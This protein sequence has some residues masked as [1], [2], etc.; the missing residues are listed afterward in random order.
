[1]SFSTRHF[2]RA[3]AALLIVPMLVSCGGGGTV[4]PSSVSSLRLLDADLPTRKAVNYSP[5]RTSTSEAGLNSEVIPPEN[6]LQDLRLMQAAGFRLIRVFDSSD[7]IA[8]QTIQAIAANGLDFKVQ[9]G[10][11]ISGSDTAFNQAEIARA[12]ALANAY[13]T[14]VR[15]VSVGNEKMASFSPD[16]VAP[17][18]LAGYITQVRN[19]ITQ[20][21]T[22]D[23]NYAVWANISTA[24]SGAV[25]YASVHV[26]PLLDTYYD[27]NLW[28]WRQASVPANQRG[29]A[30]MAAAVTEARRQVSTA[31]AALDRKGLAS[32]PIVIG[33]TGW[34]AVDTTG[35]PNLSNRAGVPNQKL[36]FQGLQTWQAEG[37][38]GSGPKAIF[39]FEAFDEQ[40]KQGDDG[41][42][43]FN[44]NR[45]AR[46]VVQSQGTCNVTWTCE[47]GTYTDA[48][49]V[50][51]IPPTETTP[52][53]TDRY[54][55]YSDVIASS[56]TYESA[57][58]WDAFG[59]NTAVGFFDNST[60]ATGD[61]PFSFRITP[62]PANYGWGMLRQSSASTVNLSQFAS[63]SLHVS[64]RTTYP[65]KIELGLG[66]DTFDRSGAEAYI[67]L[68]PGSGGYANDDAWH[69]LV[70][71]I[72]AF[73]AVNPN[74][75][76][77]Y[78][79]LRFIIAN[80]YSATGN[81]TSSTAPIYID[82]V[83][84]TK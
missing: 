84:W 71:P 34:T 19:A 38:S 39:Y 59:G 58:T 45:E 10:L 54:R 55:I 40:W 3:V 25:D 64:I 43:L 62:A 47:A 37:V 67:Q 42:G 15:A 21:V 72:S 32:M 66:T 46:Y 26:Y 24:I 7:K 12:I 41:W 83:Y 5:F 49:A 51:F 74:I 29:A 77:R 35:G 36:Y 82:G 1:M 30:M 60:S 76:L 20:P 79:T 8:K 80:R 16:P 53:S 31:R 33:E 78:V 22:T 75:D 28:D 61:S 57:L 11:F 73:T 27:P 69:D 65:G 44:K 48:D 52:V 63:G 6:I 23:D 18:V 68:T 2:L 14:I 9:L 70:I 56:E 50:Y 13:P 81:N 4:Q 17:G